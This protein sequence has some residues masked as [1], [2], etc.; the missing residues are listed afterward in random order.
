MPPPEPWALPAFGVGRET[1]GPAPTSGPG[2]GSGNSRRHRRP[3]PGALR[4]QRP[5]MA[6]GE[7]QRGGEPG[8]PVPRRGR[9]ERGESRRRVGDT[10]GAGRAQE[11]GTGWAAGRRAGPGRAPRPR[12]TW[13]ENF[14]S[15]AGGGAGPAASKCRFDAPAR[16]PPRGVLRGTDTVGPASGPPPSPP[17]HG[18]SNS[19]PPGPGPGP[20]PRPA[21]GSAAVQPL[22]AAPHRSLSGWGTPE[23][24][25]TYPARPSWGAGPRAAEEVKPRARTRGRSTSQRAELSGAHPSRD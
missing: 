2:R 12:G 19:C 8:A 9:A 24:P 22:G 5:G 13:V 16:C 3:R 25:P 20:T 18:R 15:E 7:P 11:W 21:A 4:P 1:L 23:L 6:R 10:A 14:P 17:P